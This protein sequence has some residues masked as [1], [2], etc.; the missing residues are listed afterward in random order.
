MIEEESHNSIEDLNA[1][2]DQQTLE[3]QI[4]ES[5]RLKQQDKSLGSPN[6][7]G[8]IEEQ[9]RQSDLKNGLN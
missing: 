3:D 5:N 1:R 7:N 2:N 8:D 6:R 9:L 4:L